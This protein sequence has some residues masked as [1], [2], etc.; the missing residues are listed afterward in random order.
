MPSTCAEPASQAQRHWGWGR[1]DWDKRDRG[2][3]YA[4]ESEELLRVLDE[5]NDYIDNVVTSGWRGWWGVLG[6]E[7]DLLVLTDDDLDDEP[8]EQT[9]GPMDKL[10]LAGTAF[11]K[12]VFSVLQTRWSSGCGV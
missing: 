4:D 3:E 8:M 7:M 5:F 2:H 6:K 10:V 12:L 1:K 11:G 9:E